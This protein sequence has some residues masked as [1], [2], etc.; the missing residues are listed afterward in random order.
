MVGPT[1]QRDLLDGV[2]AF[3]PAASGAVV[4]M[5]THT[6]ARAHTRTH[7]IGL[8]I[9]KP[10]ALPPRG[11]AESG[12][13]EGKGEGVLSSERFVGVCARRCC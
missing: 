3:V 13:G 2:L 9:K 5:F 8:V 12:G 4:C 1:P 6:H 10:L 7:T 11:A